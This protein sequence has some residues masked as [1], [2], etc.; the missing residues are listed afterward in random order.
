MKTSTL[1]TQNCK[2]GSI[3]ADYKVTADGALSGK[4][5]CLQHFY[6]GSNI[7]TTQSSK[8][9]TQVD[10]AN[11]GAT[12][13]E[14]LKTFETKWLHSYIKALMSL[15]DK[16]ITKL[17]RKLPKTRTRVNWEAEFRGIANITQA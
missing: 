4:I 12:V 5:S 8:M 11:L 10:P 1:G 6:E 16:G 2:T 14:K 9:K 13:V 3:I 17:R 7:V 15:S